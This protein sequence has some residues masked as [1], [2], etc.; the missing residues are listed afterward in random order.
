MCAYPWAQ[1][2]PDVQ[3]DLPKH[4]M[5]MQ[6]KPPRNGY[7]QSVRLSSRDVSVKVFSA[8]RSLPGPLDMFKAQARFRD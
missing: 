1:P 8:P 7:V 5:D 3:Y 2:D 6:Y 4:W